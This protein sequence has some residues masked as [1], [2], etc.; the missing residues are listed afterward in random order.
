MSDKVLDREFLLA[1]RK[2]CEQLS[3][4]DGEITNKIS[5]VEEAMLPLYQFCAEEFLR[6]SGRKESRPTLLS[7][8]ETSEYALKMRN[9][10][11]KVKDMENLLI[12]GEYF[13]EDRKLASEKLKAHIRSLLIDIFMLMDINF[14]TISITEDEYRSSPVF[15]EVAGVNKMQIF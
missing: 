15:I 14:P 1:I 5:A 6:N 2:T 7:I 4:I 10:G 13:R 9:M 11:I 3:S 8:D 12:N